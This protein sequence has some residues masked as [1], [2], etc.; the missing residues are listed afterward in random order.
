MY[1][2]KAPKLVPA[3]PTPNAKKMEKT[4]QYIKNG[5]W[6]KILKTFIGFILIKVKNVITSKIVFS[7]AE[8][9]MV[10]LP[11]SHKNGLNKAVIIARGATLNRT[12]KDIIND[13]IGSDIYHL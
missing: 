4:K 9:T 8:R 5:S 1:L 6:I 10:G 3:I 7:M 12:K 13:I 2:T 11:I